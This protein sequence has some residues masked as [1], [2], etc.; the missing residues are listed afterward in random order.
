MKNA[1]VLI[2][3]GKITDVDTQLKRDLS[4]DLMRFIGILVVILAHSH[5]PG[6]L[7]QLRNFGTPLLV[8]AS[9]LTYSKIYNHREIIVKP[10]YFKRLSKLVIPTWIFLSLLFLSNYVFN[11][12]PRYQFSLSNVLQCFLLSGGKVPYLFIFK[13]YIFLALIT[14]LVLY[15]KKSIP[16][17]SKYY[18]IVLA[19][20][21]FY[22]L[23]KFLASYY[24]DGKLLLQLN[25][26]IFGLLAFSIVYLYCLRLNEF[27]HRA[28]LA[29]SFLLFLVFAAIFSWKF[30]ETGQF[31]QTQTDKHPPGIYYLSYALFCLNLVYLACALFLRK[32]LPMKIVSWVSSNSLWVYLWHLMA[33]EVYYSFNVKFSDQLLGSMVMLTFIFSFGICF[34]L[35][36]KKIVEIFLINSQYKALIHIGGYLK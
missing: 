12:S 18:F 9:A 30:F 6:W 27:N 34:T 33:I 19:S 23:V 14:P 17:L 3:E 13:L 22:E 1:N 26:N 32:I 36:Q 16:N 29:I 7:F 8:A 28:I 25:S 2:E 24:V 5:P 35:L 15:A 20:Y 21:C 4:L 31:I 10:F 11:Y